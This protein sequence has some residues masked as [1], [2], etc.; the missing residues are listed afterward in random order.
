MTPE[1]QF[2]EG[3]D[4]LAALYKKVL[5]L[6]GED[7]ERE[8]LEKT[9]MRVAKAMQVLTRGYT[10]DPHKVLTDALF[11]EKYNQ[12]VIVKD[13]DFFSMCEHH[14]IPF[15]GKAHVAYIP[16]GHITGLSK[17][18]RVV[19]IFSHRLQVQERLTE[20][21]MQ[22]INDTLKP[23][24]VMVVIEAKHMCMQM[25][26]VE[27]QNAITTTSAYS[28]VFESSKTRNEFMDLLRGETKRI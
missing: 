24:G 19:D 28:G 26:G 1:T 11:E 3:L 25:R 6:L 27:K 20:Q 17:I 21:V 14:M 8:G 5:T 9:P 18:A 22:C 23:Q 2:R 15:Y 4:E 7:P 16:N 10:Q 12:M 13:I